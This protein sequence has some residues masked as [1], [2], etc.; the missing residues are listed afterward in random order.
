MSILDN[1]PGLAHEVEQVAEVA[2]YLGPS[3]MAAIL[4]SM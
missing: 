3:V 1:R 2:G 4:L